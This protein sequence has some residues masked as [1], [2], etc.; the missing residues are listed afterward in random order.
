MRKKGVNMILKKLSAAVCIVI[1]LII[2]FSCFTLPA[3]AEDG[4]FSSLADWQGD[5]D[6]DTPITEVN[7]PG[8]HDSAMFGIGSG[9]FEGAG[10]AHNQDLTFAQQ[11]DIGVRYID[12]RF[13]YVSKGNRDQT[14]NIFCC[15]GG[16]IPEMN[17]KDISL[18]DMLN[19]LNMFLDKHPTEFI[20]L[21]YKCESEEDMESDLLNSLLDS[22]FYEYANENSERYM[23][24]RQGDK[25]PTVNEAK[26]H[27]I[28]TINNNSGIFSSYCSIANNY[29]NGTD[30]KVKELSE[31]FD[32][33]NVRPLS[34]EPR[35]YSYKNED[36]PKSE[37][38]PRLIHTSCYQAPFRTP[39]R[40]SADIYKWILGKVDKLDGVTHPTFYKGY[41]YGIVLFDY[42]KEDECR[43]IVNL[44]NA[45]DTIATDSNTDENIVPATATVLGDSE[46][47]IAVAVIAVV[48][49]AIIASLVVV[50]VKKKRKQNG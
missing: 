7:I 35:T 16:Y 24:A 2:M 1:S 36:K 34:K 19:E 8:T 42:V 20:F 43:L 30:E 37:R 33:K 5:L 41:Y 45:K 22:I 28:F 17:G 10:F 3:M 11:L 26:G 49:A 46:N 27:I 44:N 21:P 31:V 39:A 38:S 32:I 25:V 40:T 9:I 14:E 15:H 4:K 50:T 29:S 47:T 48:F 13:C 6:G 18:K 12:G 23:I